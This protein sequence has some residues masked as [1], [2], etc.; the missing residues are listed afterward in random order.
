MVRASSNIC[1]EEIRPLQ[2]VV[3]AFRMLAYGAA[4]DA[5]DEY[6]QLSEG[7][8]LQSVKEF[9]KLFE[10]NFKDEYLRETNEADP[11]RIMSINE[12]RGFPVGIGSIDCQHW[13]WKNCPV[14]WAGQLKGEDKKPTVVLEA[15][16]DGELWISN[17]HF[18]S[19]GSLNDIN[20]LD[21]SETIKNIIEGKFPP[22]I[23]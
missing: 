7:S 20:I 19:P 12:C 21:T 1:K 11:R 6:L 13:R 17:A 14:T 4:A 18:G 3:A 8:V 22:N 23:E 2:R 9:A 15:I 10:G 16:C 5:L